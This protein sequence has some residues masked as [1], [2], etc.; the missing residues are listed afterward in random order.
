MMYPCYLPIVYCVV[1]VS[2]KL[3]RGNAI[4]RIELDLLSLLHTISVPK[5]MFHARIH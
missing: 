2:Y 1:D 3:K 4:N 5:V